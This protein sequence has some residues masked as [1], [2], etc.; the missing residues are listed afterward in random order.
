MVVSAGNDATERPV[1]PDAFALYPG[2]RVDDEPGRVPVTAVGALNPDSS[3]ALFSND[4]PWVRF[5]RPGAA[6]VSCMPTTYDAALQP[7]NA[8]KNS[9]G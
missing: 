2:G 5:L 1:N 3:V 4:G 8:V 9:R 6:L 7:S